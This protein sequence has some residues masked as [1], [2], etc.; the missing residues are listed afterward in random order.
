MEHD[1]WKI[2]HYRLFKRG[3]NGFWYIRYKDPITGKDRQKTT[4]R[5]DKRAAYEA[6]VAFATDTELG[7]RKPELKEWGKIV[8]DI[9]VRHRFGAKKRGLQFAITPKHV[10]KL[11]KE[12]EFHC[13]VSGIKFHISDT[14]ISRNPWAPSIDRIDNR[15]GYV[16]GNIR[17]VCLAANIAMSNWGYDI[18]LRLANGIS[19]NAKAK[20]FDDSPPPPWF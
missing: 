14:N 7:F 4:K 12:N 6:M 15:L 18:L 13:C 3:K 1:P 20:F 16:P 9:V 8:R 10:E 17:M 5:R 19:R 2:E 11:L